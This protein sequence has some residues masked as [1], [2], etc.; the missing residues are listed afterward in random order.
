MWKKSLTKGQ[1]LSIIY[2]I[3]NSKKFVRGWLPEISFPAKWNILILVSGQ[4]LI[5]A[6]KINAKWN[7]LQSIS[8]RVIKLYVNSIQNEIIGYCSLALYLYLHL[9]IWKLQIH[10]R[11]SAFDTVKFFS[12]FFSFTDINNWQYSRGGE[13]RRTLR[14]LIIVLQLRWLARIFHRSKCNF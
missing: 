7:S 9:I 11:Y 12:I 14:K 4:F 5:T 2:F 6:Y 10:R 8:F 1:L 13:Q 3:L